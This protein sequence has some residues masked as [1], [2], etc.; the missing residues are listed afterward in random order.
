MSDGS[1]SRP[2]TKILWSVSIKTRTSIKLECLM[3]FVVHF[4]FDCLFSSNHN[5]VVIQLKKNVY[6]HMISGDFAKS[7][8]FVHSL[9]PWINQNCSSSSC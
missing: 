6:S 4:Q 2:L 7:D 3:Y 1:E 8:H 5:F 9:C